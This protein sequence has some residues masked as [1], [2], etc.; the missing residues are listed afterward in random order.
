MPEPAEPFEAKPTQE[1]IRITCEKDGRLCKLCNESDQSL[2]PL[3]ASLKLLEPRWWG[4]PPQDDI[5]ETRS[6]DIWRVYKTMGGSRA[7]SPFCAHA[8]GET[9]GGDPEREYSP[10][11]FVDG[12]KSQTPNL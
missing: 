9:Y 12:C 3:A 2:D 1:L 8:L 11:V 4:Y 10:S 6:F 7:S 5:Y